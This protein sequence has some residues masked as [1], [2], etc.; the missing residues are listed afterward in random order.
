MA[1]LKY[2]IKNIAI[3]E[4]SIALLFAVTSLTVRAATL[5]SHA[6]SEFSKKYE[7]VYFYSHSC[8]Y[9]HAFTPVLVKYAKDNR[10]N[11]VGFVLDGTVSSTN[12]QTTDLPGSI[13]ADQEIIEKFFGSLDAVVAPA[14]F[15]LNKNNLY[16]Y[17]VSQGAL[18]YQELVIRMKQLQQQI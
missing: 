10:I 9:C 16:I 14:L 8:K 3:W 18:S 11:I 13:N 1:N 2:F 7:L 12:Q 15:L 4:I 17:P 5:E 6:V